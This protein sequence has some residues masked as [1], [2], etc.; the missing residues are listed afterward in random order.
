MVRL[1][2]RGV[3]ALYQSTEDGDWLMKLVNEKTG[4]EVKVGEVVTSFRGEKFTLR[5]AELPRHSG[6]SGRVVVLPKGVTNSFDAQ[7][8]FPSVFDLKFV[9]DSNSGGG[10]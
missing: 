9:T 4:Q 5:S 6:S 3:A 1:R 8:F 10:Q 7:E 2:L